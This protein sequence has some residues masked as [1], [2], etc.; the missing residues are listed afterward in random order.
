MLDQHLKVKLINRR[1]FFYFIPDTQYFI[2][3]V[4]TSLHLNLKCPILHHRAILMQKFPINSSGYLRSTVLLV[5]KWASIQLW[6]KQY[7]IIKD[8]FPIFES[9]FTVK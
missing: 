8:E 3:N 7:P 1:G 6:F 4:S 2:L 5:K 9:L